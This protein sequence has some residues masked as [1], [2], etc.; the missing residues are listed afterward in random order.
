MKRIIFIIDSL[1][2]G[3]AERVMSILANDFAQHA[4]DITILSKSHSPAFYHLNSKVKLVYPKTVINYRNKLTT[5]ITRFNL[6]F[7]IF[8]FLKKG[9]PDLVIPFSTT[10]NGVIIILC[11][12]LKM[13]VIAS[14]HNNFKLNLNALSNWY[15]KRYIYPCAT[16]LTVLTERDKNEYYS[17]F[18]RNVIVMPNP[19][20]L[21]PIKKIDLFLRDKVILAVANVSRWEQKG[22]DKLLEIFSEIAIKYPDWKLKIAGGGN[23]DY[24]NELIENF[25]LNSKVSLPGEVRDIK[26]LMQKSSI[27][28]MTSRW[29][30]LPMVLI[31]AMSQG[32]ACIAFDCFTGPGDVI[33][34]GFDGILVEDQMNDH[35]IKRLSDLIENQELRSSLGTNAIKTS[36]RYL[37]EKIVKRWY[38]LI[39]S[40]LDFH[41]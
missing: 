33:T 39:E 41:E 5:I 27:F 29:E 28:A 25:N 24:L 12:M 13:S 37:P 21:E 15:I 20:S 14:E 22:L 2:S 10:T 17:K 3:G 36:K 38:T 6:Y 11:K 9:K 7:E 30:G 35:F 19:L 4:Y 40:P 8:K 16:M 34:N 23:K 18:M 31:E 1:T 26:T 32:M